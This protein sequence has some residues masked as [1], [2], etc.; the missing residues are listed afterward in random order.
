M[1]FDRT[2]ERSKVHESLL[3]GLF[4]RLQTRGED[5]AFECSDLRLEN[6]LRSTRIVG[7]ALCS[8]REVLRR[9]ANAQ[10]S[11]ASLQSD[12]DRPLRASPAQ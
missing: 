11:A 9:E 6:P 10:R 1:L 7:V 4:S 12:A 8:G 5:A 2:L 3:I